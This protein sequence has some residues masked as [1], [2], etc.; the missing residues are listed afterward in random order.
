MRLYEVNGKVYLKNCVM[1]VIENGIPQKVET[2]KSQ[3]I[4][5]CLYS[6]LL[7]RR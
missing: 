2:G 6:L 5:Y 3:N 1:Y 4:T 7:E